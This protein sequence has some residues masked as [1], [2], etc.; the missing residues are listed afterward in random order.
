[1][2]KNVG[3]TDKVVRL[4]LALTLGIL[5]YFK[6]IS[7]TIA[8]VALGLAVIFFITSL[9]SFC[10]IWMALGVNTGKKKA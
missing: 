2:K 6:V 4:L 10:P 3:S 1:M 5:V 8:Y 9:I 7:G